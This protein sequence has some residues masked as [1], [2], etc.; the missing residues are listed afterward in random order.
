MKPPHWRDLPHHVKVKTVISSGLVLTTF[1][2]LITVVGYNDP[3]LV[4]GSYF[5]GLVVN[6]IWVWS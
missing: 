2:S 3:V 4:H 5:A 6:L 1:L